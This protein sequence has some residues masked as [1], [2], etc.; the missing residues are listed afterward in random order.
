MQSAIR[1]V[2]LVFLLD[3]EQKRICLAMKKRGFGEGKLNG[4]G[5]KVA[6]DESIESAA[7][8]EA[9]EELGVDIA[10]ESL[11]QS[12]VLD[13][14]FEGKPEWSQRC[15]VFLVDEWRGEPQESEEMAPHWFGYDEIPFERMWVD[16]IHW[17][18]LV[19]GGKHVD[20]TFH[21]SNDG[22]KI[23]SHAIN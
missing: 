19:L 2:T 4:V 23:L 15:H 18:P 20:A 1:N 10:Q 7:I 11:V 17:L 14:S 6:P 22:S 9:K 12:G 5:G 3:K 13:F 16:D 8:R 21:F